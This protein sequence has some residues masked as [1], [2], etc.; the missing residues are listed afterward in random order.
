[1]K[2]RKRPGKNPA[3]LSGL[4]D[5]V[6]NMLSAGT[7]VYAAARVQKPQIEQSRSGRWFVHDFEFV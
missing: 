7:G 5:F 3:S 4:D 6:S 1:V 2:I